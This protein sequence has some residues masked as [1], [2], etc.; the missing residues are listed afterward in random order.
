M[1]SPYH[2]LALRDDLTDKHDTGTLRNLLARLRD[3]ETTLFAD[4][5]R[6]EVYSALGIARAIEVT[7]QNFAG[8][9]RQDRDDLIRLVKELGISKLPAAYP[10]DPKFAEFFEGLEFETTVSQV[11]TGLGLPHFHTRDSLLAKL[12]GFL[13]NAL[14]VHYDAW[15]ETH[16]DGE[17][18]AESFLAQVGSNHLA[19]WREQIKEVIAFSRYEDWDDARASRF[20]DRVLVDLL[21]WFLSDPQA[22]LESPSE[23]DK[24]RDRLW[25]QYQASLATRFFA[26]M[27]HHLRILKASERKSRPV[28]KERSSQDA[29]RVD[30][31]AGAVDS[32]RDLLVDSSWYRY[33]FFD[34]RGITRW[35]RYGTTG[36]ENEETFD[37]FVAKLESRAGWRKVF[38]P[39]GAPFAGVQQIREERTLGEYRVDWQSGE[40]QVVRVKPIPTIDYEEVR[41]IA[42]D[43]AEGQ[44]AKD[45]GRGLWLIRLT[46]GGA[47]AFGE[48]VVRSVG[49]EWSMA[50][51]PFRMGSS[52]LAAVKVPGAGRYIV[53]EAGSIEPIAEIS[54]QRESGPVVD[55]FFDSSHSRVRLKVRAD[56]AF[57][58]PPT[59]S[60]LSASATYP[61]GQC[62][63]EWSVLLVEPSVKLYH[64]E[65]EFDIPLTASLLG[66]AVTIASPALRE[67]LS[68]DI[69]EFAILQDSLDGAR[70][71]PGVATCAAT[72]P[73]KVLVLGKP[74][75]HVGLPG[76]GTTVVVNPETTSRANFED[77]EIR[78]SNHGTL[79]ELGI[80]ESAGKFLRELA[81]RSDGR[82]LR[83]LR[84]RELSLGVTP[85]LGGNGLRWVID[86]QKVVTLT[87]NARPVTSDP[88]LVRFSAPGGRHGSLEVQAGAEF[89]IPDELRSVGTI[90]VS[91]QSRDCSAVDAELVSV[92]RPEVES[93][94]Y[95]ET[96]SFG[97]GLQVNCES[98]FFVQSARGD[99]SQWTAQPRPFHPTKAA[100]VLVRPHRT[101]DAKC[102]IDLD[103]AYAGMASAAGT[104]TLSAQVRL[105][106]IEVRR[107]GERIQGREVAGFRG[108]Q[109]SAVLRTSVEELGA[110]A[111]RE[112]A[113]VELTRFPST[114]PDLVPALGLRGLRES[115]EVTF[116][117]RD[118]RGRENTLS[119][120][121]LVTPHYAPTV[122]IPDGLAWL[123]GVEYVVIVDDS[124]P[125]QELVV[126]GAADSHRA[127]FDIV[128]GIAR[129]GC[130][131]LPA[132]L[133]LHDAHGKVAVTFLG[134]QR[135]SITLQAGEGPCEFRLLTPDRLGGYAEIMAPTSVLPKP[136][137]LLAMASNSHVLCVESPSVLSCVDLV[138]AAQASGWRTQISESLR[139]VFEPAAS[140]DSSSDIHGSQSE[141]DAGFAGLVLIMDRNDGP[142]WETFV[143]GPGREGVL[144]IAPSRTF[145]FRADQ[146]A[147][148]RQLGEAIRGNKLPNPHAA[149]RWRTVVSE[150]DAVA[151][152]RAAAEF[153][154]EDV[155]IQAVTA[156]LSDPGCELLR[157]VAG[158]EK[159]GRLISFPQLL[160][161]ISAERR[162][163]LRSALI[164][165]GRNLLAVFPED[166]F[167][168]GSAAFHSLV[169]G[170]DSA[171]G[172]DPRDDLLSEEY[173]RVW[174]LARK[175][176]W[177]D[178]VALMQ[179]IQPVFRE[180]PRIRWDQPGLVLR[181]RIEDY[182]TD[183]E[184]RLA[185][186]QLMTL[187]SEGVSGLDDSPFKDDIL[188]VLRQPH[189]PECGGII[190]MS[191]Q[192]RIC[193]RVY[194][195]SRS[196]GQ[197]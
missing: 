5:K 102:H 64:L 4:L 9:Q 183:E 1:Y 11:R 158:C 37:D 43:R 50:L 128:N 21:G 38:S 60:I 154:P 19:E 192:C 123:P 82:V 36:F 40:T 101:A 177:G 49:H 94:E 182:G 47:A 175:D 134:E 113:R 180:R 65:A 188:C 190:M 73:A 172:P 133:E 127:T 151:L 153:G 55:A 91:M 106:W 39:D 75:F 95:L 97:N 167:D 89:E 57:A 70:I 3:A 83:L 12:R 164:V 74:P 27:F 52:L 33:F 63:S 79:T 125:G 100:M 142:L 176:R 120:R 66:A 90:L 44:L 111:V 7:A 159:L 147:A 156:V 169:E 29:E 85:A 116:A 148:I 45:F 130:S 87:A 161:R 132:A 28:A 32:S 179:R 53:S 20:A 197:G 150:K 124:R 51:R 103:C 76:G 146:S 14:L 170:W 152:S 168:K 114:S 98:P 109:V 104:I 174:D 107:R 191:G 163:A 18:F 15:A 136:S 138:R 189:C 13:F 84:R 165:L 72:G 42:E 141:V 105:V 131:Y 171:A 80:G 186:R 110:Y 77:T 108:E 16:P 54:E 137:D 22:Y 34:P 145:S 173:H 195:V 194:D 24:W 118:K 115:T 187:Q 86:A 25:T 140:S 41:S 17:G 71:L 193:K 2:A 185:V 126:T 78:I 10:A 30:G 119:Y 61:G 160:S 144:V 121:L 96:G 149:E 157:D 92:S 48:I 117:V 46:R 88:I 181:A 178:A 56:S 135:N 112:G 59:D 196:S 184:F 67:S 31:G 6:D 58:A 155:L 8:L 93:P 62:T 143:H 81:F 69:P 139:R 162:A 129:V 99:F 35:V 122:S 68:V 166:S 26:A 23:P